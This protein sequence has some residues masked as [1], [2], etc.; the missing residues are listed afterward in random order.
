MLASSG[1]DLERDSRC[2]IGLQP[3]S[4]RAAVARDAALSAAQAG[5]ALREAASLLTHG[6]HDD[7]GEEVLACH[8]SML[9]PPSSLTL[10]VHRAA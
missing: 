5:T 6:F 1:G 2:D 8:V 3:L 9:R 7:L 4:T 10:C